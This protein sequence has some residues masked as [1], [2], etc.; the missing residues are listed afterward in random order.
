MTDFTPVL[1][2]LETNWPEGDVAEAY[3][4]ANG[5]GLWVREWQAPNGY[6]AAIGSWYELQE[7]AHNH[8]ENGPIN[9]AELTIMECINL[10]MPGAGVTRAEAVRDGI[11][12]FREVDSI[13]EK[14]VDWH[15]QAIMAESDDLD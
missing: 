1:V 14:H 10:S 2:R 12:T 6:M 11:K 9:P 13:W 3:A 8:P 7:I 4:E 15:A 5:L